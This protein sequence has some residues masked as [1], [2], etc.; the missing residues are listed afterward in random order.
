MIDRP[1]QF[2]DLPPIGT[3]G[4]LQPREPRVVSITGGKPKRRAAP[5]RPPWF[6]G[7]VADE[8]GRPMPI[9]AN[10]TL[11]LRAAP[12]L[13]ESFAF[14]ELQ[15]QIIVDRELPLAEG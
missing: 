2:G 14:D 13:R 12:E 4:A 10:V 1:F 3:P 5:D 15:R 8:R 11:A 9:L 6:A 7:A